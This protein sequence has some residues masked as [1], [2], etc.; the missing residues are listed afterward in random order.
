MNSA[1]YTIWKTAD[2][3]VMQRLRRGLCRLALRG[4][5]HYVNQKSLSPV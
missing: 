5:R 3:A 1:P 2:G 4:F